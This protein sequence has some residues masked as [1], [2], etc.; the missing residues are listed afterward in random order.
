MQQAWSGIAMS[1]AVL[2]W[3][4]HDRQLWHSAMRQMESGDEHAAQGRLALLI[5]SHT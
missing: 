3:E 4:E 1:A 2:D 5:T